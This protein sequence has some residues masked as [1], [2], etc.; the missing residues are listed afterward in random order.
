MWGPERCGFLPLALP[1]Y[2]DQS[3]SNRPFMVSLPFSSPKLSHRGLGITVHL[4]VG[5]LPI[6]REACGDVT[7]WSPQATK[8]INSRIKECIEAHAPPLTT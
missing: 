1:N 8:L 4:G 2:L 3:L 6:V 5:T 7:P